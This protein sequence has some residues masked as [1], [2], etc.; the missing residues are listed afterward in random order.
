M[1]AGIKEEIRKRHWYHKIKDV[2]T[3]ANVEKQGAFLIT[4]RLTLAALTELDQSSGEKEGPDPDLITL[5]FLEMLIPALILNDRV[6]FL[7]T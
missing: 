1:G 4:T 2:F 5:S 6:A 3:F 7:I